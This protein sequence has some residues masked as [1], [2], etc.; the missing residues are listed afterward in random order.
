MTKANKKTETTAVAVVDQARLDAILA[1]GKTESQSSFPPKLGTNK[2][3]EDDNGVRLPLGAY[4]VMYK[5]KPIY[6]TETKVRLGHH[7]LYRFSRY[8]DKEKK[9]ACVTTYETNP[10]KG[11]FP[12][13]LGTFRC[14]KV[15]GK[16]V[17][18]LTEEEKDLNAKKGKYQLVI[19]CQVDISH[20]VYADGSRVVDSDTPEYYSVSMAFS[21]TRAVEVGNQFNKEIF[22]TFNRFEKH[23]QLIKAVKEKTGDNTYYVPQ[24]K[25]G[26]DSGFPTDISYIEYIEHIEAGINGENA[27]ILEAH[28]NANKSDSD[29]DSELEV[30][31]LVDGDE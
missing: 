6:M 28:V 29:Y 2:E 25:L 18:E 24:F 14:G 20:A 17:A 15:T 10:F 27:K 1:K 31:N 11:E 21:G 19:F 12:D 16:A 3:P 26:D 9:M 5:D 4:T 30:V 22:K 13:S 7:E 8:N 23:V